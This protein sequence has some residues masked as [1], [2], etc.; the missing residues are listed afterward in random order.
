M[1]TDISTGTHYFTKREMANIKK[2]TLK[3]PPSILSDEKGL[4]LLAECHRRLKEKSGIE[5][6]V[7][8]IKSDS[9]EKNN[10]KE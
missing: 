1:L 3:M 4:E 9:S 2:I 5:F 10:D 6:E 8:I 7:K